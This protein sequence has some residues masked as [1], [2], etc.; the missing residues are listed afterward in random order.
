MLYN[1]DK[2]YTLPD[3]ME[4][5]HGYTP[6]GKKIMGI[7]NEVLHARGPNGKLVALKRPTSQLVV[8]T[9]QYKREMEALKKVRH[10]CVPHFVTGSDDVSP[11]IVTEWVEGV[12]MDA[13]LS[14]HMQEQP[15]VKKHREELRKSFLALYHAHFALRC[16]HRQGIQ[17]NDVKPGNL[18]MTDRGAVLMDWGSSSKLGAEAS[19]HY[20]GTPAYLSPESAGGDQTLPESDLYMLAATMYRICTG[21]LPHDV[22]NQGECLV[23]IMS[24]DIKPIRD[25]NPSMP[26]EIADV[27]MGGLKLKPEDRTPLEE[28]GKQ[29]RKFMRKLR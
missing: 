2:G 8:N 27:C 12:G 10:R 19:P 24:G 22:S 9:E 11:H 14:Q 26:R 7:C 3:R 23:Q 18:H 13:W 29:L 6:T 25:R 4:T 21:S 17:H 16:A 15:N 20:I 1:R 5:V 28:F